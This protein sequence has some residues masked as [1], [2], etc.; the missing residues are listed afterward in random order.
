M[1]NNMAL[2]FIF[3]KNGRIHMNELSL[4]SIIRYKQ[5]LGQMQTLINKTARTFWLQTIS[6]RETA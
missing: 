5:F 6:K 3:E 4:Y 1:I 2:K